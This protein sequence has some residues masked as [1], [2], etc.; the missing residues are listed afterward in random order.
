LGASKPARIFRNLPPQEAG[1][2][3]EAM[4]SQNPGGD[5]YMV[6][7]RP[8][9]ASILGVMGR[10]L[11]QG[12][13]IGVQAPTETA[14]RRELASRSGNSGPQDGPDMGAP[15]KQEGFGEFSLSCLKKTSSTFR[16]IL[17]LFPPYSVTGQASPP[18]SPLAHVRLL[19]ISDK[20]CPI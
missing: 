12:I 19:P 6:P 9:T 16:T 17:V 11:L 14:M 4:P 2:F 18:C 1:T 5:P 10:K 7:G 3:G 20:A 13:H 8:P 15:G